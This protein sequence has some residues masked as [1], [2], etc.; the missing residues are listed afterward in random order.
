MVL[1]EIWFV[2][3][4]LVKFQNWLSLQADRLAV[5]SQLPEEPN[6]DDQVITFRFRPPNGEIFER[7]FLSTNQLQVNYKKQLC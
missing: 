3:Y 5:E 2:K 1:W 7:K 6:D 4:G